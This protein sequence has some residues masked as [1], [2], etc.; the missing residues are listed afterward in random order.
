VSVWSDEAVVLRTVRLGEADRIVTMLTASL[1]KV[2]A[3]AKGVRKATSRLGARLDPPT[4]AR[5]L[6]WQGREL[7]IVRQAQV[8]A[9]Y[10]N[11]RSD[12][13]RVMKAGALLE[14]V[15]R[16]AEERHAAERLYQMLVGALDVLDARDP[17]VLVGAFY[18]KLLALEGTRPSVEACAACGAT[19]GLS[20]FDVAEGGALCRRCSRGRT[21]SPGALALMAD[22]LGG[23]LA[24][25]LE[26]PA[27]PEVDEVLALATAAMEWHLERRLRSARL[28]L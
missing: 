5:V 23:R 16:V 7:D 14:A 13:S 25:A 27:S 18:L 26:Q 28:A 8:V 12:L 17:P 20:A 2:R 19:E 9:P 15:E 24:R 6:C 10:L 4:R 11:L 21:A 22:V 3:V 1:G